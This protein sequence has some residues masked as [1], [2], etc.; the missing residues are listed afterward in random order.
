MKRALKSLFVAS[1]FLAFPL[2]TFAQ[3]PPHPNGG[4]GQVQVIHQ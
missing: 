1:F 2:F 4:S 3:N